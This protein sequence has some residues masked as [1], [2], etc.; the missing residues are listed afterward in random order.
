M[1]RFE[2]LDGLRG[3]CAMFVVLFHIH[4]LLSFAEFPFFRNGRYFVEFFFILS[5]FV[6]YFTYGK[7]SFAEGQFKDFLISRTFRIF[8]MHVCMLLF[9]IAFEAIKLFASGTVSA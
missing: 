9:F 5:G 8:P 3:I 6:M 4:V 2:A 1:K 7:R